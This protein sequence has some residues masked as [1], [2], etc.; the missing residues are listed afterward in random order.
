[1]IFRQ[2][3]GHVVP[4]SAAD[5]GLVF[6]SGWNDWLGFLCG[7]GQLSAS[8]C[9]AIGIDPSDL[10]TASISIGSLAGTQ[11]VT[12]TVTNVGDSAESYSVASTG[13][14][15]VTAAVSPASF[16]LAPGASQEVQVTF[17]RTSAALTAYVGGQITWTGDK[18]HVVR[19]PA[20]V[21]PVALAAPATVSGTGDPISYDVSFGYDGSFSAAARGL[22]APVVD[23]GTVGQDPDQTFTG[24]AD[25]EGV[26]AVPV[27]IPAGST[28]ARFALFDSDV[29]PGTDLDLYICQG[30]GLVGASGTGTSDEEVNFSF[31]SPTGSDIPLTAYVHGWGVAGGGTSPFA[32]HSWGVPATADGTMSVAAPSSATLGASGTI[33]LTFSGLDPAT[34]YLGS[35]AYGGTSGLPSPTIVTVT[36]P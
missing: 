19:V 21:R 36:T 28:Y 15:G 30:S 25:T 3:A 10:N 12:R 22:V 35:V 11:T 31:A 18:G 24:C 6:D 13:L 29:T 5:P 16:S 2:G 33:E 20:V 32:L 23:E 4:N 1:V 8:Y 27:V 14:S 34:R 7:T 9:P 26:A 17:S